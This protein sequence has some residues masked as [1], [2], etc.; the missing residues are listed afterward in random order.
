M[1]PFIACILAAILLFASGPIR[2]FA[3]ESGEASLEEVISGILAWKKTS[4]GLSTEENLLSGPFSNETGT[5]DLDWYV[6]GMARFGAE[7]DYGAYLAHLRSYVQEQ[8]QTENKLD[9]SKA[10]E[11]H[12]ITLAV[13]ACGGDP[14]DMG[15]DA[16]G[17]RIDLIADG[18]Y[19]RGKTAS[20]GKQGINGWIWGLIALDSMEYDV[21]TDASDTRESI[22]AAILEE[23]QA[24]GGWG[25]SGEESAADLTAMALQALA[26]Y[27]NREEVAAATEKALVCLS[28]MQQESGGFGGWNEEDA[29]SAAQVMI[30]L[31]ALGIDPLTDERFLK[32][33]N[34][35][36]DAILFYRMEDGGFLHTREE[37]PENPSAQPDESNS[38]AGEQTLCALVALWRFQNGMTA[39]YDFTD[40]EYEQE[41]AA[42]SAE[43]FQEKV[44][45]LPEPLTMDQEETVGE[46][47]A[48]AE[49]TDDFEGKA[50]CVAKL[51]AAKEEIAGRKEAVAELNARIADLYPLENL[52]PYDLLEIRKLP[53][54]YEALPE[55]DRGEIT[56]W[57]TVLAA[58]A[59]MERE[60]WML[61]GILVLI[62]ANFLFLFASLG[63]SPKTRAK[64]RR[65]MD[66]LAAP[67]K[68]NIVEK[69]EP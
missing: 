60:A 57:D 36:L 42:I 38:M 53:P 29:E 24:D 1:K 21:P 47:L 69:A 20:L 67:Y 65:R 10:T 9:R 41:T 28:Q 4:V 52:T 14:T 37:D 11:W 48:A 35:V 32:N 16:E 19:N 56:D 31:C 23:Q 58:K 2:A 44:A 3:E 30:A 26:P 64:R 43:E 12:R 62:V 27:Q 34:T 40:T 6:I 68:E 18:T 17:N 50:E 33:G 61:G 49:E 51:E 8:Y 59:L 66:A 7:E 63:D 55:A 15:T 54:E 45:A 46:L 22:L 13:L 5:S 25:L 39:L